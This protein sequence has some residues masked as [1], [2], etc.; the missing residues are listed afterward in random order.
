MGIGDN[1]YL[2][3]AENDYMFF[4]RAYDSGNKGGTLAPIGQNICERYLKHIIAEYSEP[5]TRQEMDAKESVLRTHSLNRLMRYCSSYMEL[6][7]PEDMESA[8]IVADGYYFTSR[9][10]GEDSF[11]PTENDVDKVNKAV[12]L[13]REYTLEICKEFDSLET[14]HDD[15]ER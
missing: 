2:D 7:I 8:L 10:P 5:E 15:I 1:N 3:F 12:E 11:I 14:N 13:T 6:N 9:Y 4:R